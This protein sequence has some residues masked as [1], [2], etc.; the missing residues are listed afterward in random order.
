MLKDQYRNNNEY[1]IDNR[2][3]IMINI[4][5]KSSTKH[6]K[7]QE[8]K[9]GVKILVKMG[10]KIGSGEGRGFDLQNFL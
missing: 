3:L 2:E 6:T 8:K 4:R 9:Y 5:R 7:K 1:K 10:V